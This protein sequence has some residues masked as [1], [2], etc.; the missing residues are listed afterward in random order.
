[1]RRILYLLPLII[2]AG[3]VVAFALRLGDPDKET[4]PS[5]L[6][7]RKVPQFA[8]DP[9]PGRGRAL[10]SGDLKGQVSLLNI[11]GSW[12]RSCVA[13]HP[14]LK[15]IQREYDIP[16]HGI[17]WKDD[18]EAG[19]AWLARHGDPYDRIGLDPDS[20]VA[21]DLGVTGAPETFIVGPDGRIRYKHT[22]PITPKVWKDTMLPLIRKLR[23]TS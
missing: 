1:M 15:R 10:S 3:L 22:G 2:L 6:I 19:K 14:M 9:L 21:I 16:L 20:R 12:C 18:P 5:Q 7:D 13:E 17:D 11:F 8:L 4:L 23:R